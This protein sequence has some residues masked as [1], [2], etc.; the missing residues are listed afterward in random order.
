GYLE[1][2]AAFEAFDA[3]DEMRE[4]LAA[5]TER[6]FDPADADRTSGSGLHHLGLSLMAEQRWAE[7]A[8]ALRE[9]LSH[10]PGPGGPHLALFRCL[11]RLQRWDE[12]VSVL[13]EYRDTLAR[14]SR[15]Y[16]F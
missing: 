1:L 15:A 12:A 5:A 3:H 2:A 14:R 4:A 8:A 11:R 16:P 10:D 9:S 7:A 13:E 6:G